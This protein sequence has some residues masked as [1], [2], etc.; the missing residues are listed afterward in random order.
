MEDEKE[1]QSEF[2]NSQGFTLLP[3]RDGVARLVLILELED[4][5]ALT[6]AAE[7]IA[8]AS[9]NEHMRISFKVAGAVKHLVQLLDHHNDAVR[10]AVTRALE[11]LSVRSFGLYPH[12]NSL[13]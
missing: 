11:R 5:S 10:L 9:I 8:D 13:F 4:E 1:P 12:F 3:W 2:S 7:S 6:R